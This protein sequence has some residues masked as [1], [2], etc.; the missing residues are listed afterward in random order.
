MLVEGM[1]DAIWVRQV[2]YKDVCTED[3]ELALCIGSRN[4]TMVKILLLF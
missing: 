4:R 2:S 3:C 1:K